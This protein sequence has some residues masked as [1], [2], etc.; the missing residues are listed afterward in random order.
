[1]FCGEEK[2]VQYKVANLSV[3]AYKQKKPTVC[4][5]VSC[6]FGRQFG[7]TAVSRQCVWHGIFCGV[8]YYDEEKDDGVDRVSWTAVQAD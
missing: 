6:V 3:E 4:C 1:M 7:A 8:A 5:L 2:E